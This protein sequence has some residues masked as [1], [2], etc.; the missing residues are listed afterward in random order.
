MKSRLSF[1]HALRGHWQ[2]LLPYFFRRVELSASEPLEISLADEDQVQAEF[3]EGNGSGKLVILS[4]GLEGS[5]SAVYLRALA[6]DYLKAGWS[7]LAW[8]FRGCG[9]QLNRNQRLYHSGAH[10]DLRDVVR[11]AMDRY[12]PERLRLAGFSLGGNLTLVFAAREAEWIRQLPL[13][14]VAAISPP[15]NLAASSAKLDSWQNRPYRLRFMLDLKEKARL[16]EKQFPGLVDLKKLR[17]T[18]T[19]F[20]FDDLVTGP[21]HGFAGAADY[22][23]KCSSLYHIEKIEVPFHVVLAMN[24]PMLARGNYG[25]LMQK[26]PNLSL[27][28]F[29]DGGHCG[30]W[31]Q[32]YFH[33]L[34]A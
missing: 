22:Y 13:E 33:L 23:R 4:H 34:K 8:N 26:N 1:F 24:D 18:Q 17:E 25:E 11:F 27:H 32:P 31:K 29:P 28:L 21:L 16:K 5:T 9:G 6:S 20:E 7:V 14:Q 10:E 3:W 19:L 30:F 15:L 12:K 2:T